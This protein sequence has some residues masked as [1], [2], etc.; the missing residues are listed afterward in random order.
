[1]WKVNVFN[2]AGFKWFD[3]PEFPQSVQYVKGL[4]LGVKD[5][6]AHQ[7]NTCQ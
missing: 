1:M 2:L 6:L 3:S 4:K 5:E 7:Q